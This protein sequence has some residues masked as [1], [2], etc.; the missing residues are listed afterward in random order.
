MEILTE[1]I[2]NLLLQMPDNIT[3]VAVTKTRPVE[4]LKQAYEFGLRDFGENRVQEMIVKQAELPSD[5]R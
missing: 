1:H 5:I 3:L 4:I 2:N